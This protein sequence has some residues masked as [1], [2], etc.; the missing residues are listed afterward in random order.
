MINI[1]RKGS[2]GVFVS[3]WQAFLRGQGFVVNI[4][5][6]FDDKTEEATRAF[7]K[8]N[9]LDIDGVV[10]NQ[11][12]GTAA[13]KGFEIVDYV[14]Q[15]N[16]F[17]A[18]PPFPPIL[19]TAKRQNLF[20]P[21]EFVPSP[22]AQNPEKIK[23]TNN[24]ETKNI[25]EIAIPQLVE[26]PGASKGIVHFHRLVKQQFVDLWSAWDAAGLLRNILSYD[27]DYNPRF[28]RGKA[29]EQILSNH[30][31][32]TAFDINA[33]WNAYGAEPAT[34]GQK[35]CVYDLVDIAAEHGFYWGG[36]FSHRDGMHFEIAKI[37]P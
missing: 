25:V 2:S 19:G 14:T 16:H 21:L 7:Q 11:T 3:Q 13:R 8:A 26:V 34:W 17:P 36:F 15:D 31:F 32:G 20:G 6:L 4:D 22:T 37:I 10:G 23:I 18:K 30:A 1:L 33:K 28:I 24:F 35:G 27:G 5:G 9:K 12:L 29:Q